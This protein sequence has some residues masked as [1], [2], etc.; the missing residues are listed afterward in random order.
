MWHK[1]ALSVIPTVKRQHVTLRRVSN[2]SWVILSSL[3]S[4][5]VKFRENLFTVAFVNICFTLDIFPVHE[6]NAHN[7]KQTYTSL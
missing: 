4:T 7:N 3:R 6:L 2:L 5:E 1:L